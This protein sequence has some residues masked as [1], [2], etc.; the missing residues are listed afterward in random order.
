M[1]ARE[2]K[3]VRQAIRSLR[4]LLVDPV[5]DETIPDTDR[6]VVDTDSGEDSGRDAPDP[7]D[8]EPVV[9]ERPKYSS[10]GVQRWDTPTPE[11]VVFEFTGVEDLRKAW[12]DFNQRF[13]NGEKTFV[14]GVK[15]DVG[16]IN[17][18]GK[19]ATH[20]GFD[21]H[22]V[23]VGLTDDAVIGPIGHGSD[24]GVERVEFHNIGIRGN[25]D[26]FAW[27]Q[28]APL[29]DVVFKNFWFVN[30]PKVELYTS[31]IHFQMGWRSLSIEKYQPRQIRSREHMAYIKGGGKTQIIDNDMRGGNRSFVHYRPH[32]A[33]C[34]SYCF[35]ATP[36]PS[37]PILIEGNHSDGFGWDHTNGD[38][39]A[40]ISVWCSLE[41]PLV[42]RNN[43]IKNCRYGGIMVGQGAS[44]TNVYLTRDGFSHGFVWVEDNVL[45]C[46]G[47]N[48]SDPR[49]AAS[50]SA[51]RE[52]LFQ[53]TNKFYSK[54]RFDLVVDSQFS[55][56]QGA[57]PVERVIIYGED[58]IPTISEA[59]SWVSA[60]QSYVDILPNLQRMVVPEP[61]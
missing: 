25:P 47:E 33:G 1:D 16:P 37:G 11:R 12:S 20:A 24:W 59:M 14:V 19:Y 29:G 28:G 8:D 44:N 31:L 57:K 15:G 36:P 23:F 54:N 41:N 26:S 30:H 48:G 13:P 61:L 34:I 42:I 50:F 4:G 5:E 6:E 46:T 35:G 43:T 2:K 18:G 40:V 32:G 58:S 51:V 10:A 27:R 9:R 49:H 53:G 55:S 22:V 38:G 45:E 39:G 3:I 7:G 17:L 60:T 52:L 21:A 56:S